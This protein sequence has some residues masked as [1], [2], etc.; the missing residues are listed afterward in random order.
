[1]CSFREPCI[2][3]VGVAV[4]GRTIADEAEVFPLESPYR[5]PTI[6]PTFAA[7]KGWHR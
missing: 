2:R 3:V 6:P 7:G 1:M 4:V 5:S